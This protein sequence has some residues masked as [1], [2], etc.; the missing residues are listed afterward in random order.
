VVDTGNNV[1]A[2]NWFAAVKA[3]NCL[4]VPT[5][6]QA[7]VATT[8]LW[9]LD[10]LHRIGGSGL[11]RN[12]VAVVTCAD[13]HV[14]KKLLDQIVT[15]YQKVVRTVVVV[16]F[17]AAIRP[18]TRLSYRDLAAPTRRAY[19]SAAVAVIDSLASAQPGLHGGGNR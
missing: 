2:R 10:H 9:M 11:V 18:G 8:G 7:D 17:D 12:A 4:V 19:L 6:V 15:E 16:P 5:S 3:A 14:D 1:R 13:P